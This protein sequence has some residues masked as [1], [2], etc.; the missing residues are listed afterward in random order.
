VHDR[1][2]AG[3]GAGGR[4][5]PREGRP[6][7]GAEH[8]GPQREPQ[9]DREQAGGRQVGPDVG[10]AA[11][12]VVEGPGRERQAEPEHRGGRAREPAQQ[13][14]QRDLHERIRGEDRRERRQP[15]R[16]RQPEGGDVRGRQQQAHRM[17]AAREVAEGAP[18]SQRARLLVRLVGDPQRRD[19][20]PVARIGPVDAA[21]DVAREEPPFRRDRRRHRGGED[22]VPPRRRA[23]GGA[24]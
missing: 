17:V 19:L 13:Q 8:P 5:Q 10:Q 11:R 24:V 14:H 15:R 22:E 3:G 16:A 1:D 23:H 7:R 2:E 18:R 6:P 12:A 20:V 4:G 21:V 9:E